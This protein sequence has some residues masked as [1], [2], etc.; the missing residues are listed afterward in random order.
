[1]ATS[2]E[3]HPRRGRRRHRGIPAAA[4]HRRS[5]AGGRTGNLFRGAPAGGHLR[6]HGGQ[7]QGGLVHPGRRREGR[8]HRQRHGIQGPHRRCFRRR[9]GRAARRDPVAVRRRPRRSSRL[10]PC[11]APVQ[12]DVLTG[13]AADLTQLPVP[14][15]HGLDGAPYLSSPIDVVVDPASG[16]YNVGCRRLMLRGRR[17]CGVDLNAPSDLKAIYEDA[18]QAGR[19][20][21]VSFRTGRASHRSLHRCN[22][23]GRATNW[24]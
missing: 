6:T 12:E 19:P 1:M 15:Q 14:F 17:S 3:D 18:V 16:L 9:F 4:L 2:I 7:P 10:P 13:E 23:R 11:D 22:A 20:L 8:S 21:P 24:N 5:R